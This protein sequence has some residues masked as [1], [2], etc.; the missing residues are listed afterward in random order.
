M[1]LVGNSA[2]EAFLKITLTVIREPSQTHRHLTPPSEVQQRILELLDFST[3]I[4]TR[5]C[6]DLPNRRKYE[7]RGYICLLSNLPLPLC[8][9]SR[10]FNWLRK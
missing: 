3:E 6:I 7:R 2:A 5:L 8:R 4:Y 9:N 1:N 10:P